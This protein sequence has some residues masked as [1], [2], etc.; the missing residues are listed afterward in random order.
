MTALK[1]FERLESLG[2]W[3]ASTDAQR[4]EVVVSFGDSTLVI[5]DIN[6]KPLTHWS[7]AAVTRL[8][9]GERPALFSVDDDASETL[10][11]QDADMIDAVEKIRTAVERAKPRPGR[12][13]FYIGATII[14]AFIIGLVIWLPD[15]A[16]RYATAIVPDAKA[17]DLG[18][19]ALRHAHQLTGAPCSTPDGERALR[20]LERRILKT[21]SN[22]IY[23]VEMGKRNSALLPGG[24]I[25]LNKRLVTDFSGPDVL[26]SYALLERAAEDEHPPLYDLFKFSGGRE[27]LRF[28]ATGEVA[29][30]LL[31]A[32]SEDRILGTPKRPLPINLAALFDVAELSAAEFSKLEPDYVSLDTLMDEQMEPQ[33]ILSD[34]EWLA[35]QEICG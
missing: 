2:L 22:R 27:T 19:K 13:R 32:F 1:Q 9:P 17:E 31:D 11:I 35:L 28:L 21:P 4:V 15:A 20:V 16:A 12:L 34:A 23:I 24:K 3:R 6:S 14:A 5:S 33:P 26:S 30:P 7:L 8:N 10:E 18:D 29:S 25:L